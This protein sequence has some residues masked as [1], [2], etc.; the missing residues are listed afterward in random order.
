[1]E[2][3]NFERTNTVDNAAFMLGH[4]LEDKDASYLDSDE[5]KKLADKAFDSVEQ[6]NLTMMGIV[7]AM[8][9]DEDYPEHFVLSRDLHKV[10]AEIREG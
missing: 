5:W 7:M 4:H 6:Y 10:Y 1:M 9:E 3:V 2:R 8:F